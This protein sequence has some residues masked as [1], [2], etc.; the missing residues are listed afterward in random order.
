MKVCS[1]CKK[2]KRDN[3][4]GKRARSKDGLQAQCLMCYNQKKY[5]WRLKNWE[6]D[7][8]NKSRYRQSHPDRV[9]DANLRQKYGISLKQYNLMFEEQGGVCNICK[10]PE[11]I[12]NGKSKKIA[13]LA[14]DHC[15]DSGKVR[16]LLCFSCNI[17]L[18]KF[19]DSPEILA[20]AISHVTGKEI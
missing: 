19:Q 11:R 9:R 13:P 16:G 18:G 1:T 6:R 7:Y 12:V 20:R 17:A 8:N 5:E 14:V 3:K 10:R 2:R 15:H 4:F